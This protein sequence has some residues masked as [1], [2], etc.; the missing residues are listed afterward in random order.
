[1]KTTFLCC[2]FLCTA[3]LFSCKNTGPVQPLFELMEHT[4]I[5]FQNNVED[6]R[7]D[8]SFLF[9]NF[10][11]GGGVAI[12]DI[13]N[14]GLADIFLTSNS[15]S[16]KLYLN[17]GHFQFE[18]I[19]K[20]AGILEDDKWNTG[21]V[22]ADVNGDGWLDIY[23]SSSGHMSTGNRKNKLYINNHNLSFTE[24]AAAYGLDVSGYTTQVSFFDYDL[25]GDLD[26]FMINNSPIPVNQLGYANKRDLPEQD[27]PV[28]KF[29]KGGG[30]H[31][32]RNDNGHFTEVTKQAGI[33]GTLISFGLGVSVGD[34]NHDG[35]PDVFVSND[36][37]E[38]DYLY[39]NQKNGTFKDALEDY[40]QHISFS[41][42]GAD[43][44]DI[45][46]DGEP[47]LFT[48]DMLPLNDYRL[49]TT[50]AFDNIDIFNA[51]LKAG[52]Y[53]QYTQN[54]L[55][56]NN[57]NGHFSDIANYA[58][59]AATD[60]SWG[61]LMFDMDNDGWN[62]IYVCNGVNR[63]VTNLDFMNFF[64]D[65]TYHKMVL[66]GKKK[67]IDELLKQ[68]PRTP[69]PNKAFRNDHDLRFTDMG[70]GWGFRDA[71]FSNGAAYGDLDNDGDLD[72]VVNNVN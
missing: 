44:A 17:K 64:A 47:D 25:D 57:G 42:M 5:N 22:F 35:Y 38:R 72:L 21:V 10:Y 43:I 58:G 70:E 48:T 59:V 12:G 11:N 33:H 62:D 37:Y 7:K 24:S 46:N 67:E 41:S 19:S 68:I 51:K 39:I 71:S 29:L 49:K 61:A 1:M 56:L 31:L 55:Q 52:F 6:E 69:L 53:Y 8:N 60:W 54:C 45:N 50:G 40:M 13:N 66:S 3:S 26:C 4:G 27:W 36:S 23:V 63:D 65:E 14:D 30:D 28:G 16:N 15:G 34:I 20:I 9:R 2:A 32:Y 18:D